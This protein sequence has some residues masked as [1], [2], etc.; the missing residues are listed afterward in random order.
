MM[1]CGAEP[2]AFQPSRKSV[3][4]CR[5]SGTVSRLTAKSQAAPCTRRLR[6]RL[7][8]ESASATWRFSRGEPDGVGEAR[9][10]RM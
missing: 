9:R 6:E 7:N 2:V 3:R 10:A 5:S 1:S 8:V 4:I